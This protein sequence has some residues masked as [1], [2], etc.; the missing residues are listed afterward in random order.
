MTACKDK[1]IELHAL[2]DGELDSR[3]SIVAEEHIRSCSGCM[4]ELERLKQLRLR[5]DTANLRYNAPESL[6][7]KTD[8][9]IVNE[10]KIE[11]STRR[12]IF[13]HKLGPWLGGGAVGAL[14]ASMLLFI[15]GPQLSLVSP[16]AD[17][18]QYALVEGHIRSLQ[19][20]HLTD[21]ATSDRHVVKPWFNGRIDFAP[22]VFD[23]KSTGFPLVGGRL[24]YLEG[25]A[26]AALVYRSRLHYINLYIRPAPDQETPLSPSIKHEGYNIIHWEKD[27]LEYWAVSDIDAAALG[28]FK[29][30]FCSPSALTAHN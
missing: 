18:I 24:D 9:I 13:P 22:P 11:V 17:N 14:A 20:N 16:P 28:K 29:Q 1:G 12:A 10:T 6:R 8:E 7:Q 23:L 27:D 19:A 26:V 21:I 4:E 25:R 30:A 15:V 2:I 3:N 5:L